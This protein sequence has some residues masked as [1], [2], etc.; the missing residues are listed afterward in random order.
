MSDF[1]QLITTFTIAFIFNYDLVNLSNYT[2][3]K[4]W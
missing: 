2:E 3:Q 4:H 1:T